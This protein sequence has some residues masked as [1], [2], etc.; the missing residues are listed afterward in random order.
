[1]SQG[2][3]PVRRINSSQTSPEFACKKLLAAGETRL[4]EFARVFRDRE[5]G[6]LHL[7]EFT[8]LEWYRANEP[9]GVL[10]EDCAA[11]MATAADAAGTRRF[12]FRGREAD[13]FAPPAPDQ[14]APIGAFLQESAPRDVPAICALVVDRDKVL[15][16]A[17]AGWRDQAAGAPLRPDSIFRIASMTKPVTSLAVMMLHEQSRIGF[18]DPVTKYLPE[19]DRLRV[20]TEFHE[21]GRYE[22]RPPKRAV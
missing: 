18:D 16:E 8:M 7:P 3:P 21:D 15:F 13:P 20:M 5:R 17:A 2:R 6:D 4:F 22:S 1:M 14:L 19:F 10:I 11:L 12:S 9:Y